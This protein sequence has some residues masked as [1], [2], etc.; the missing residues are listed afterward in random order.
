[1]ENEIGVLL[2]QYDSGELTRREVV[3]RLTAVAVGIAGTMVARAQEDAPAA[4]APTFKANGLNH[5]AL[6]VTDVQRARDFYV[7]HLGMTVTRDNSGSCF[8]TFGDAFIA[9]FQGDTPGLHHFCFSIDDFNVVEAEKRLRELGLNPSQPR[10]T[11]R[12]Y[13]NDPDGIQLQL[14]AR[15]HMPT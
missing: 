1:M 14:A 9:L 8:A 2:R 6:R 7:K 10:G 12:I 3:R 15:Q 4:E 13:F 11:N 5:I